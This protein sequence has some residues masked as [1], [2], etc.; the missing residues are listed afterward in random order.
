MRTPILLAAGTLMILSGTLS[1]RQ[2]PPGLG[3]VP[4]TPPVVLD[5]NPKKVHGCL[6]PDVGANIANIKQ[7][8]AKPQS[9][10]KAAKDPTEAQKQVAGCTYYKVTLDS[11]VQIEDTE[12]AGLTSTISGRGSITFGLAPDNAEAGYDFT[13][14]VHDL[15][16]PIFWTAGSADITRPKCEVT[17]TP[18]PYTLFAFWLGVNAT[19]NS[20]VAVRISPDGDELHPIETRCKDDL[21]RWS[22]RVAGKE[23]IFAPAWIKLHGEGALAAPQTADQREMVR[24]TN[25][26]GKGGTPAPPKLSSPTGDG[27]DMQ[28]LMA[29]DPA[30][31][32]AMAEKLDPNNPADMAKI[33]QLM[34]GVVPNANA[35]LAA[36]QDNF[37]F[38]CGAVA[39]TRWEC[40]VGGTKTTKDR[41][42]YGTIKRIIEATVITIEK[43]AAPAGSP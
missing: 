26:L 7:S 31:L 39:A 16:A 24:A 20:K 21:G 25:A 27:I 6:R 41:T 15:T 8:L 23:S 11:K 30:K 5:P 36:A 12:I 13:S 9:P 2:V 18:L 38:T 34:Q 42:G 29:M 43:V 3:Q 19:P 32:A 1:A 14:G 40:R 22:A 4:V 17:V 33:S 37:M 10:G 35:Q 28:K